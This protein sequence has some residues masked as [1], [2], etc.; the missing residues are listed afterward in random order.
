[1]QQYENMC[2]A[3]VVTMQTQVKRYMLWFSNKSL[4]GLSQCMYDV[5]KVKKGVYHR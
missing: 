5:Q 3:I 1:M 4:N 2:T